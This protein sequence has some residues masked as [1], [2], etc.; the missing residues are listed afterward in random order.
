MKIRWHAAALVAVIGAMLLGTPVSA[1]RRGNQSTPAQRAEME[2]RLRENFERLVQDRLQLTETQATQLADVVLQFQEE[3]LTLQRR[4][5]EL[6]RRLQGQ[7]QG[8]GNSTRRVVSLPDVEAR[9]VLDE[10]RSLQNAE[11]EIFNREHERLLQIM[12]PS[13]LV[14]Y[15]MIREQL[16]ESLRRVR[17]PGARS[18]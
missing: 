14:R 1:Q 2:R 18:G 9:A 10:M 8:Q 3:R 17:A 5:S 13:Q 7:G 11:I 15:Y 12:T 4:E 16:A 6:R